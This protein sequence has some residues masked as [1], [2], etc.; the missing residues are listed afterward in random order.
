MATP[1]KGWL[2][3]VPIG[4]EWRIVSST[5]SDF[6]FL[7]IAAC[8]NE[9]EVTVY[10]LPNHEVLRT[11]RLRIMEKLF[12]RLPNGTFFK[13]VSNKPLSVT[14]VGGKKGGQDLDPRSP[15]SFVPNS[16]YTSVD[17][18]VVGREF[19]F[20]ASQDPIGAPYR[21]VALEPSEVIIE[22]ENGSVIH[23]FRLAPSEFKELGL[24]PS[25]PTGSYQPAA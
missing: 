13:V 20:I 1:V 3:G 19:I 15:F 8:R 22:D 10:R 12:V 23:R 17:G 24:R 25:R 18:G 4:D 14:L 7:M 11:A 6:A 9:T 16:F 5:I 21:I 2:S